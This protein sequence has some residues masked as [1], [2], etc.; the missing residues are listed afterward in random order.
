MSVQLQNKHVT[1][2]SMLVKTCQSGKSSINETTEHGATRRLSNARTYSSTIVDFASLTISIFK[3][4]IR[5]L[6]V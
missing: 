5:P 2:N 1:L 3:I 4:T 6:T